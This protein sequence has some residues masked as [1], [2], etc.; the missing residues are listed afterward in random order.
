[1]TDYSKAKDAKIELS[2]KVKIITFPAGGH[3][4]TIEWEYPEFQCLCPVSKRHDQGTVRLK[5][6]PDEKILESKSIREYL[7]SW[8]N[9]KIWQEYVTEEIADCLNK[10]CK[11]KWIIVEIEWANRGGIK[12]KTISSR[13]N[14]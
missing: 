2:N 13:G 14:I 9:L 1:M 11:P 8:R 4:P 10:S 6:Q 7:S 12:A 5:Y 3:Q